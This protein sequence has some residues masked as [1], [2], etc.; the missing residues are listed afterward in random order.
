MNDN[1]FET[2]LNNLTED[3]INEINEKQHK[4]HMRQVVAFKDGYQKEQCYLCGRDFKTISKEQP[5]LHWLLRRGKF[6][7]NDFKLIYTKFSY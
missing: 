5:C 7:K 1:N 3:Q 2:W 6:K 4:E